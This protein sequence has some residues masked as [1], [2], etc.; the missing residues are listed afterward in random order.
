[1]VNS[2]DGIN[3]IISGIRNVCGLVAN[4]TPRQLSHSYLSLTDGQL[5]L[6]MLY[7]M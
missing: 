3:I 6:L 2:C 1:M 4:T 5:L 7:E